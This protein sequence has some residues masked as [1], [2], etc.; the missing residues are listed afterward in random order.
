MKAIK[1]NQKNISMLNIT[2][3][4][5]LI[6]ICLVMSGCS[7]RSFHELN[8]WHK[9][10]SVENISIYVAP[11][12]NLQFAISIDVVFIYN[13]ETVNLIAK[14]DGYQWY[15]IKQ[16]LIAGHGS[17]IDV[18]E[19]QMVSGFEDRGRVLPKNH[20]NAVKVLAFMNYPESKATSVEITHLISPRLLVEFKQLSVFEEAKGE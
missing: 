8:P 18:L 19:W 10:N 14:L 15:Q 13:P 9:N 2:R 12:P 5:R 4:V 1:T 6:I 20:K 16:S 11:D 3:I 7:I 17:D